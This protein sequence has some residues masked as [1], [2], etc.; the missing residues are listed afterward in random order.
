MGRGCSNFFFLILL[1]RTFGLW[2]PDHLRLPPPAPSGKQNG[3]L[4]Q[5]LGAGLEAGGR[6]ELGQDGWKRKSNGRCRAAEPLQLQKLRKVSCPRLQHAA[7][8]ISRGVFRVGGTCWLP[9][10]LS[11]MTYVFGVHHLFAFAV[12]CLPLMFAFT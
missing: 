12:I 6:N 9:H 11:Y 7:A 3:W 10:S 4:A 8:Y 5:G 2:Y 1:R